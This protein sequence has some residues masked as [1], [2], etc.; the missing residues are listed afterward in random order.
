MNI[1]NK[2][3]TPDFKPFSGQKISEASGVA[4]S[5][6]DRFIIID[7]R[8]NKF[9]QATLDD[10]DQLTA[11]NLKL[12]NSVSW[13]L[14]DMEGVAKKPMDSWI[15]AITSYSGSNKK[16]RQQLVRF[17]IQEDDT[18]YCME[19]V[20]NAKRLKS[21]I[22]SCL[23]KRFKSLPNENEFNIES[24]CWAEDGQELL[25]GL[26]SPVIKGQAVIV[27]TQGIDQAFSGVALS[28][29]HKEITTLKLKG[30][31]VRAMA[32]IPDLDGYLLISGKNK[33][34]GY[35]LWFW[36]GKHS[37][38]KILRFPATTGESKD[39]IQPEGLC[40]VTDGKSKS[41]LIVSDDGDMGDDTPGKYW[42]L[43]SEKYGLL[44]SQCCSQ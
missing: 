11:T 27:R 36:D 28:F 15:Y 12:D 7:D 37:I 6:T 33:K 5:A 30:G 2:P 34:D 19:K 38:K 21:R 8:K 26:R 40:A 1:M 43:S 16:S 14:E 3:I 24:L 44:K 29:L 42:L 17:Q 39:E 10:T 20:K 25:I 13:S 23:L 22:K 41:V 18:I 31:G 9:F 4:Q 35:Y 32:H